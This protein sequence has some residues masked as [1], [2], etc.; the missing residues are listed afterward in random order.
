[1]DLPGNEHTITSTQGEQR[2]K[3]ERRREGEGV[4]KDLMEIMRVLQQKRRIGR[5]DLR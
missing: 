2:M 1:M 5:K 3:G 4:G